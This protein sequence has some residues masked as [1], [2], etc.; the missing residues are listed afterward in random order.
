VA[1]LDRRGGRDPRRAP[2]RL[3]ARADVRR[4]LLSLAG[5]AL[6]VAAG[7]GLVAASHVP[8]PWPVL[9]AAA[10]PA[11]PPARIDF[12][13]VGRGHAVLVRAGAMAVL[14]DGG[15]PEAGQ[16]LVRWLRGEGVVRLDA[17]V[18]TSPTDDATGGLIPVLESLPVG[19]V[20]DGGWA[21]GCA[22]YRSLLTL[23]THRAIPVQRMVQGMAIDFGAGV[24]LQA[25]LP[26]AGAPPAADESLVLRLVDGGVSVLLPGEMTVVQ[27]PQ[28]L[29]S[30][31]AS[32]KA[33]VLEVPR[34]GGPGS[35][36]A[37]LLA[38]VRPSVAVIEVPPGDPSLPDAAV[39][40]RLAAAGVAVL[41]SDLHGSVALT[42]DGAHLDIHLEPSPDPAAFEPAVTPVLSC[43]QGA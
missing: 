13:A 21:A 20:L 23:A 14:V 4:V 15:A 3:A 43:T 28:L 8:P 17:V 31:G 34:H 42:T 33:Q 19:R 26:Q 27:A 38:S 40:G 22:L 1:G 39:T 2:R 32:L 37:D 24:R 7:F 16:P 9:A 12:L 36:S 25:L 41:R 18:V 35:V 29:R 30:A 10:A 5:A 6:L 11:P